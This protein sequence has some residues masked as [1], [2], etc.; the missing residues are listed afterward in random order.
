MNDKDLLPRQRRFLGQNIPGHALIAPETIDAGRRNTQERS[1]ERQVALSVSRA[2]QHEGEEIVNDDEKVEKKSMPYPY[3][4]VTI[5]YI[6]IF[7][8]AL[9]EGQSSSHYLFWEDV[10]LIPEH[11]IIIIPQLIGP[12]TAIFDIVG[13]LITDQYLGKFNSLVLLGI[14]LPLVTWFDVIISLQ[15]LTDTVT[16][17]RALYFSTWVLFIVVDIFFES[18][19]FEGDQF[20]LP[21]QETELQRFYLYG[22]MIGNVGV[23]LAFLYTPFL[24]KL[25]VCFGKPHCYPLSFGIGAI[26]A[27]LRFVLFLLPWRHYRK[28]SPTPSLTCDAFG[29]LFSSLKNF[30]CGARKQVRHFVDYA[31]ETYD[32]KLVDEVYQIFRVAVLSL[33]IA[34]VDQI[35]SLRFSRWL[36]QAKRMR[37]NHGW[38]T[39]LADNMYAAN[40]AMV[41]ILSPIVELVVF[42][43]LASFGYF[44]SA[45]QKMS[46]G[47]LII[48]SAFIV[49]AYIEI[50]IDGEQP[51]PPPPT[52]V[53]LIIVNTANQTVDLTC[54]GVKEWSIKAN[55]SIHDKNIPGISGVLTC[56]ALSG[57]MSFKLTEEN[58]TTVWIHM[59]EGAIGLFQSDIH[60]TYEKNVK[61]DANPKVRVFYNIPEFSYIEFYLY[62]QYIFEEMAQGVGVLEVYVNEFRGLGDYNEITVIRGIDSVAAP[63]MNWDGELGGVYHL[64]IEITEDF[65]NSSLFEVMLVEPT[66]ISV[67]WQL[68]QRAILT[69]GE[70]CMV[71]SKMEFFYRETPWALKVTGFWFIGIV[72]SITGYLVTAVIGFE[73]FTQTIEY[74]FFAFVCFIVS[75]LVLVSYF[76]YVPLVYEDE[77]ESKSKDLATLPSS[78]AVEEEDVESDLTT[79]RKSV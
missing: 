20:V 19:G 65:K 52:T 57:S 15:V 14:V 44:K 38:V 5:F 24:R 35:Y 13:A 1:D 50:Q 70:V 58:I 60:D 21:Q 2:G 68:P 12:P 26:L 41:I 4:V 39:I 48:A 28:V 51:S 54:P 9:E 30:C 8:R 27:T 16:G 69:L 46:V 67:L 11:M 62:G 32:R 3:F 66:Q 74:L 37:A 45:L 22:Y 40:P 42:R 56:T 78:D 6:L 55:S 61:P 33:P 7:I 72:S 23:T 36:F 75:F 34:L 53:S 43:S 18:T 29:C 10:M 63:F 31:D 25:N 17:I 47:G 71:P 76:I 79:S 64:F 73:L 49:S 77:Q 59:S